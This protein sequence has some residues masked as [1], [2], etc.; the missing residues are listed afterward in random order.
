MELVTAFAF[1]LIV[2][3]G[4]TALGTWLTLDEQA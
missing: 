2:S 3:L 1:A 4:F